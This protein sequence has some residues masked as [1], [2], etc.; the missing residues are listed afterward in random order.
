MNL[1]YFKTK[2]HQSSQGKIYPKIKHDNNI[3]LA[4]I[5]NNKMLQLIFR[6]LTKAY[7]VTKIWVFKIKILHRSRSQIDSEHSQ[8]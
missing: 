8:Y 1:L 2:C 6:A 4:W 5:V 7:F 3:K